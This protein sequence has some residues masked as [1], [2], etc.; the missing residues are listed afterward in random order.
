MLDLDSSRCRRGSSAGRAIACCS[1]ARCAS[2]AA[3]A[4]GSSKRNPK[5]AAESA[6]RARCASS[7]RSPPRSAS[8]RIVSIRWN[9]CGRASSTRVLTRSSAYSARGGGA[10]GDAAAG[11]VDGGAGGSGRSR[12]SGSRRR[13]PGP[14]ARGATYADRAAVHAAWAGLDVLDELHRPGLRRAGHR[15]AGEE[16]AEEVGQPDVGAQRAR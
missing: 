11:A 9:V 2:S 16:R 10:P 8:Y 5:Y 13:R 3:R 6:A 15:S 12:R 1:P 7:E 4:A 14:S